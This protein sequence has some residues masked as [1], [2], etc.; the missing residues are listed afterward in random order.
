MVSFNKHETSLLYRV[1]VVLGQTLVYGIYLSLISI[2]TYVMT[3]NGLETQT[4]RIVFA[5]MW[6]MFALSTM[7]WISSVVGTFWIIVAWF[8]TLDPSTHNAPIWPSMFTTVLLINYIITDGVVVWRTW[9]LCADQSRA[10]LMIPVV[11]LIIDFF[12]YA[13]AVGVRGA[14]SIVR[15]PGHLKTHRNFTNIIY[16]AQAG[17]L[18]LS[19]LTNVLATSI[20]AFKAWK[21]RKSLSE[22]FGHKTSQASRILSLLIESGMLYIVIGV[23][24][25]ASVFIHLPGHT[26]ADIFQPVAVQLAGMYP[27]AVLLLVR[28]RA[29]NDTVTSSHAFSYV[30]NI[31]REQHSHVEPMAFVP[32]STPLSRSQTKIDKTGPQSTSV[33]LAFG[34][35]VELGDMDASKDGK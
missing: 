27:I 25:F 20:I 6:F 22:V 19:L 32:G 23:F 31:S 24:S 21:H 18:G 8:S 28:R 12:F 17:H 4:H 13:T 10:V 7:Y 29:A 5:L 33:H 30:V 2:L 11:T 1:I 9:V 35:L 15:P 3:R 26:L 16:V 34:S 14:S